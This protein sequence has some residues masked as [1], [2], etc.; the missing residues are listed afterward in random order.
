MDL[1]VSRLNAEIAVAPDA[2]GPRS[3]LGVALAQLR[4]GLVEGLHRATIDNYLQTEDYFEA[5]VRLP[6][7]EQLSAH[8]EAERPPRGP[9]RARPRSRPRTRRR[10]GP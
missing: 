8:R 6:A 10:S 7:R 3:H 4:Q 9:L 2:A 5:A 1:P